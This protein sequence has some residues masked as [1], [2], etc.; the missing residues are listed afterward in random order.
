MRRAPGGIAQI[1]Q[2]LVELDP[3]NVEGDQHLVAIGREGVVVQREGGHAGS[4][5]FRTWKV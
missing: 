5:T 1:E 4:N 3:Q 2:P